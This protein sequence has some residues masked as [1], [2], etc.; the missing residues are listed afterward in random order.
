MKLRPPRRLLHL[1]G[2]GLG[3]LGA[4]LGIEAVAAAAVPGLVR[5]LPLGV[6]LLQLRTGGVLGCALVLIGALMLSSSR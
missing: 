2:H 3:V 6:R 4:A 1:L 5:F